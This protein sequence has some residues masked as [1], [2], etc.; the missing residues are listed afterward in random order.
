M[1]R[2]DK[3]LEY[4]AESTKKISKE[5]LFAGKGLRLRKLLMIKRC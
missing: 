4:I 1:K 3:I 2:I 5:A